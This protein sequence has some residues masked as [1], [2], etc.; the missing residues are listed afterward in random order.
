M[1]DLIYIYQQASLVGMKPFL[2]NAP[3]PFKL[4]NV[5]FLPIP[6]ISSA[7][8]TTSAVT[9]EQVQALEIYVRKNTK[10]Q[11][12]SIKYIFKNNLEKKRLANKLTKLGYEEGLH[13]FINFWMKPVTFQIPEGFSVKFGDYF[14]RSIFRDFDF[15]MKRVF[16]VDDVFQKKIKRLSREMSVQPKIIVIYNSR[17]RPVA[18]GGVTVLGQTGWL[19]SGSVLKS[20]QGKGLWNCLLGLRQVFSQQMGV[21]NWILETQNERIEK[22]FQKQI[23]MTFFTK[24]LGS[25]VQKFT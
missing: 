19:F 18:T 23:Q 9:T 10:L 1:N 20:Y 22:K 24:S 12:L 14:D 3:S 7:Q 16:K 15:V 25:H 4:Y 13:F 8:L 6:I 11:S 21:K 17:G 5:S 2:K